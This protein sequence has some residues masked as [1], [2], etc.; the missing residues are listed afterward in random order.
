MMRAGVRLEV[1]A[2]VDRRD[3][4]QAGQQRERVRRAASRVAAVRRIGCRPRRATP[5]S[6]AT[7]SAQAPAASTSRPQ[8]ISRVSGRRRASPPPAARSA[9]P[10]C[11]C[12]CARRRARPARK[13]LEQRIRVEVEH[14]RLQKAG[15]RQAGPQQRAAREHLV[16][17]EPH[18]LAWRA[19]PARTRA[20]SF[21]SDM[22]VGID[23]PAAR[24]RQRC[25]RKAVGRRLEEA[26]A[27]AP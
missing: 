15:D 8:A 23:E 7:T 16:A 11:P 5:A 25:F 19:A 9:A 14:V 6:S 10:A 21:G 13:A 26:A 18:D 4:G 24:M 2:L 3:E 22:L 27:H 1:E 17:V 12:G 20:P